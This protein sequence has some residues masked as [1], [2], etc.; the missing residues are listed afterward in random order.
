MLLRNRADF[1]E[2]VAMW[3]RQSPY[4]RSLVTAGRASQASR[5]R[6]WDCGY[7]DVTLGYAFAKANLSVSLVAGMRSSSLASGAT[8]NC[9]AKTGST[10]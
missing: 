3:M 10:E 6:H 7:S 2:R 4:I 5:T 9:M 1:K 8:R